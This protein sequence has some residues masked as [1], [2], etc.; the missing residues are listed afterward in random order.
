MSSE[1]KKYV[2]VALDGPSGAGKSSIA[3]SVA[4]EL[5][6]LYV[7]TGAIYRTVAYCV[8]QKGVDPKDAQ[9]VAALLPE[10]VITM[11]YDGAGLQRMYLNG[12]DVTKEIRLP[13]ISMCASQ[14]S[15]IPAVRDFLLDM[16][17]DMA[18]KHNVIMDGRDI[19]TVV[20]PDADVKIYLTA[21]AEERAK[22]RH[23]ELRE[24]GTPVDY[25][26][27]LVEIEE[28]DYN[29]THRATAPLKRAADALARRGY[30]WEDIKDGL[31]RYGARVEEDGDF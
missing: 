20:L 27:I 14:V 2:S 22:R 15:E 7:D 16:Q 5:G 21:S 4:Q 6:F 24:Q 11:G 13:E 3:R 30:R 10:M 9:A 29:D 26:V 1:E 28:R 23:R 25:G 8:R 19:A 12:E 18:K 31:R 17:R